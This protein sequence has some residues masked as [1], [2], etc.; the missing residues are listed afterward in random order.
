MNETIMDRSMTEERYEALNNLTSIK[1]TLMSCMDMDKFVLTVIDII[2]NSKSFTFRSE[3][4][5]KF[6]DRGDPTFILCSPLLET[7]GNLDKLSDTKK[8]KL[9]DKITK[10]L[11]EEVIR[12]IS[13]FI[14]SCVVDQEK[15]DSLFKNLPKEFSSTYL[16]NIYIIRL[17]IADNSLVLKY[18]M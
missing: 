12:K 16:T 7:E 5:K 8:S 6:I 18:F 9:T 3:R 14:T 10:L 4:A 15:F 11:N 17:S 13:G 1:K 2:E